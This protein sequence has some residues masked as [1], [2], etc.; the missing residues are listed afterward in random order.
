MREDR[1]V[2]TPPGLRKRSALQREPCSNSES[3]YLTRIQACPETRTGV[4]A[5]SSEGAPHFGNLVV[6][7][8]PPLRIA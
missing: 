7:L 2:R 6:N 5:E 3:S 8:N 4:C 1:K